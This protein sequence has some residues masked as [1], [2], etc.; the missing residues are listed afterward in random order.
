MDPAETWEGR[1]GGGWGVLLYLEGGRGQVS[2]KQPTVKT[3]GFT[4]N[5][6][7]CRTKS[8]ARRN[9]P[10]I[11]TKREH[12]KI[13]FYQLTHHRKRTISNSLG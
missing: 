2:T 1:G 5:N 4:R 7:R 11:V 3:S 12:E 10:V 9:Y 6:P 13:T 8:N